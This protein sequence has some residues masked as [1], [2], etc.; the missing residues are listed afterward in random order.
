MEAEFSLERFGDTSLVVVLAPT[1]IVLLLA[2]NKLQSFTS[3]AGSRHG[4]VTLSP[5]NPWWST[6]PSLIVGVPRA[7][8]SDG[9]N[10]SPPMT[11]FG[12]VN[13]HA[14]ESVP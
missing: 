14:K 12:R 6:S 4:Q 7:A 11:Y 5:T 8:V 2:K 9:V 3:G 1:E 13:A 10:D